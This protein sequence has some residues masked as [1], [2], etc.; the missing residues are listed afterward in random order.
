MGRD[1][2]KSAEVARAE[3]NG[4]DGK[5]KPYCE[6]EHRL[7]VRLNAEVAIGDPIDL[8]LGMPL[9]V[10]SGGHEIGEVDDSQSRRIQACLQAGYGMA[11]SVAEREGSK[12][13]VVV[14]GEK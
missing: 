2:K 14:S 6:R 9:R 5:P 7:S 13:I 4:T 3:P 1:S 8:A 11:G 10:D 12:A